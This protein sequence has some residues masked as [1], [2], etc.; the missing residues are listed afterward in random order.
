MR[1]DVFIEY[2]K[3]ESINRCEWEAMWRDQAC[4]YDGLW[5]I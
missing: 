3:E 2:L 5:D 1:F 4:I